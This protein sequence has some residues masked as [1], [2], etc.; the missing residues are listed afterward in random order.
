MGVRS[1]PASV[2]ERLR[3]SRALRF[4]IVT[5]RH[6]GVTASD[7][8]LASYPRS[9]SGWLRTMIGHLLL[10]RPPEY[11]GW[12][13][14]MPPVGRHV[15]VKGRLSGGGRLIKS[16]ERL[17]FPYSRRCRPFVYLIRDGR[18]VAVSYYHWLQRRI[19]TDETFSAFLEAFLSGRLDGYGPWHAHV[20]SWLGVTTDGGGD[21]VLVVRYEDLLD[22]P[23]SHLAR[24]AGFL[25]IEAD[26]ERLDA[27]VS[28]QRFESMNAR[29]SSTDPSGLE[30]WRR[31]PYVRRGAAGSWTETFSDSDARRFDLAAGDALRRFGYRAQN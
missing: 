21:G 24:V 22:D 10:G 1:D 15:S 25:G 5:F 4:P 13:E 26:A 20:A 7:V 8:F 16:H 12:P 19:R 29:I 3:R 30:S 23:H 18:D 14:L 11:A 17:A 27:A 6:R 31:V 9:G 2:R 28:E